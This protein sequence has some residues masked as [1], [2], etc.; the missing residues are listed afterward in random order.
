MGDVP[1]YDIG[2]SRESIDSHKSEADHD[3]E[4]KPSGRACEGHFEGVL[5]IKVD[6]GVGESAH[7]PEA[8]VR[9]DISELTAGEGMSQLVDENGDKDDDHPHEDHKVLI[10]AASIQAAAQ[11]KAGEPEPRF[12]ADGNAKYSEL[13]HGGRLGDLSVEAKEKAC[14]KIDGP[15]CVS[16]NLN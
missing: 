11:E 3:K 2:H 4:E 5:S 1:D 15:L 8:D 6:V 13:E 9:L 7:G 14:R 12:H 10:R 16:V